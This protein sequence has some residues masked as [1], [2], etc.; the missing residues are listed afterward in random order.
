MRYLLGGYYGMRNVGDDI[1]LYVTLGEVHQA[2]PDASFTVVSSRPEATPDGV[3][4]RI[5]PGGRRGETVRQLLHHDV[6]LFGGGGLLQDG[7]PRSL[8]FLRRLSSTARIAK[9]LRRQI[10]LLG[11]GIGPLTTREGREASRRF[12]DCADFVSVRDEESAALASAIAPRRRIHVCEDLAFRLPRPAA[13]R[14]DG[15]VLGISLLPFAGSL[16]RD[17]EAD[18][19]MVDN[20]ARAL[21]AALR[22]HGHWRVK[23][24]EFFAGSRDY[25]DASVLERLRERLTGAVA[26]E[27]VPYT[28]DFLAVSRDIARCTA[29]LGMRFHACVLAYLARVSCLMIAYHPK[30]ENLARRLKLHPDAVVPLPLVSDLDALASRLDALLGGSP[31]FVPPADLE[32]LTRMAARNG[33]LLR[34]WLGDGGESSGPGEGAR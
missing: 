27:D 29:F 2:D 17:G 24:F 22:A 30:S 6:W 14:G 5:V 32:P 1:L 4:V 15:P 18:V 31:K 33:E 16:G 10:V 25:G 7:S 34:A 13:P 11:V 12:L 26:V 20:I 3:R 9:M 28:G 23:L 8:H 19:T 21:R